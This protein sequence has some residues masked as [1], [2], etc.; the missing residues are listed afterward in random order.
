MM[1]VAG[2]VALVGCSSDNSVG[3]PPAAPVD[4]HAFDLPRYGD[5]G[6]TGPTPKELAIAQ[7]YGAA[8]AA[9]DF[10]PL[11]GLLDPEAHFV[12]FGVDVR[13]REPIEKAHAMLFGAFD[14]RAVV[15]SR[16]W[17]TDSEQTVELTVR[18]VQTRP[19]MGVAPT[20]KP[21]V[22]QCLALIWTKNEGTIV[23]MHLYFDAAV[24]RTQLG[25]GPKELSALPAPTAPSG[26]EQI[27]DRGTA[28]AEL[29]A[30]QKNVA[31][32][33]KAVDDLET[34]GDPSSYA[35]AF[36][37]DAEVTT[38]ERI[39]PMR[40]KEE[41]KA[42]FKAVHRSIS[43]LDTT[44]DNSWG[45]GSYAIVEYTIDGQQV[46]PIGWVQPHAG[47]VVRLHVVD[48]DEMRD[49]KIAR[50]WRYDNPAEIVGQSSP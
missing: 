31:A 5:A 50:V 23:N 28:P 25:A 35:A 46:G 47:N 18:G 4:W 15:V 40:G 6:P 1:A 22:I 37:D 17:R 36:T 14:Q 16:V 10:G 44:T 3:P 43:Q 13:N 24:V 38:L 48:I 41:A 21:V 8:L 19:W 26:A 34:G 29:D 32:A 20:N 12:S 11:D 2:A 39:Q 9:P 49:G 42:F 45:V 27:F 7:T 33:R 30:E